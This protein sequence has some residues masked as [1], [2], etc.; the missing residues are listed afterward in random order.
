MNRTLLIRL[1]CAS[2]LLPA[3]CLLASSC[4]RPAAT[5]HTQADPP[6]VDRTDTLDDRTIDG[7]DSLAGDSLGLDDV[8][9]PDGRGARHYLDSL[10]A[11]HPGLARMGARRD[12]VR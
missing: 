2:C 6:A 11:A 12:S 5:D 1:L 9:L 4:S 3:L 8:K 7:L 10:R